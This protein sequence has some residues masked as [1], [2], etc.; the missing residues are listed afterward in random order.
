MKAIVHIENNIQ[1]VALIAYLRTFYEKDEFVCVRIPYYATAHDMAQQW[2]IIEFFGIEGNDKVA[3]VKGLVDAF[4]FENEPILHDFTEE[5]RNTF[6]KNL[7]SVILHD[8]EEQE[9]GELFTVTD[10]EIENG[11]TPSEMTNKELIQFCLSN[12]VDSEFLKGIDGYE[13]F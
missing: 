5:R 7:T 13:E 6:A 4:A 2:G 3:Y 8:I 1:T 11:K 12:W 9:D 10:T